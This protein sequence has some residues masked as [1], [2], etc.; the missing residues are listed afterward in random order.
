MLGVNDKVGII[1]AKLAGKVVVGVGRNDLCIPCLSRVVVAEQTSAHNAVGTVAADDIVGLHAQRLRHGRLGQVEIARQD[2]NLSP[3]RCLVLLDLCHPMPPADLAV[4]FGHKHIQKKG[5]QVL[6]GQARGAEIFCQGCLDVAGILEHAS[7]KSR[8]LRVVAKVAPIHGV[9][10]HAAVLLQD[11]HDAGTGQ[12]GDSR[13]AIVCRA[14]LLIELVGCLDDVYGD[15]ML[16]KKDG[17]KQ[18]RRTGTDNED[19]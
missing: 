7:I 14:G 1:E 2:L 12:L 15:A 19:L 16:G 18:T 8:N 17:Q 11:V 13:R 4:V 6:H 9:E 5:I 10:A 3:S